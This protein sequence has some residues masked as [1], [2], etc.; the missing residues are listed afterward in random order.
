VAGILV[1]RHGPAA[2]VGVGLNVTTTAEE[3]PGPEAT[4]LLLADAAVTDRESLLRSVLRSIEQRY[5]LWCAGKSLDELAAAYVDRCTT[6]GSDVTV[7]LADGALVSGR[8]T[9]I[10]PTGCLL[11]AADDGDHVFSSGDVMH[12]RR[13]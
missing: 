1:E 3:L 11:V 10:D 2:V 4:S 9:G 7:T 12:V 6:V 13:P 8:A 5:L